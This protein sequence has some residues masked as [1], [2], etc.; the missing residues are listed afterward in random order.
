MYY[1]RTDAAQRLLAYL[2]T[3]QE[4][5]PK[6]LSSHLG[7]GASALF[8]QLKKLQQQNKIT[9]IGTPPHVFYT[10]TVYS[11]AVTTIQL[12]DEQNKII[13]QEYL[14]ITPSGE[15]LTGIPGFTY[16]CKKQNLPLEKTAAEY[17]V[18][19]KKYAQYKINDLIDG[20]P[21]IKQTFTTSYLDELYY[22]DFYSLERFG[23]TKLGWLLLQAKQS[24]NM[25]LIKTIAQL[26]QKP[27]QQL[28]AT[29]KI[30]AVGFI[31]PTIKRVV[32]LQK[33][34]EQLL[35]LPLPMLKIIKA[36]K[37]IPVAQKSLSKLADRV[38][39]ASTTIFIEDTTTQY[40]T[41]L[42]IDDAVGSG[43]TLNETAKKIKA[44]HLS[45]KVI[46]L[47]LTGSFKGFPVLT[48]I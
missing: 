32:Q 16:W 6:Q 15:M 35:A 22:L 12:S 39:N 42:L 24:Q 18:T 45:K 8:R 19:L 41:I 14:T 37:H 29:K 17:V 47:A 26:I 23:K 48:D 30:S 3:Q 27:L 28:L 10:L 36:N 43:A 4:A 25:V 38:E 33:S 20:L 11:P 7:I 2:K 31:P 5:T 46:G 9:K 1:M 40:D 34:L 44:H 13:T 21:K